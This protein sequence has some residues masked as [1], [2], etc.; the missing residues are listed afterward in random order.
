M[1]HLLLA[2]LQSVHH[3]LRRL[4]QTC[5]AQRAPLGEPDLGD[6]VLEEVRDHEGGVGVVQKELEQADLH[7]RQQVD[8]QIERRGVQVRARVD[9]ARDLRDHVVVQRREQREGALL[10]E[11]RQTDK[12]RSRS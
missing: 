6:E 2:A 1:R 11:V 3:V 5:E 7:A 4:L 10:P 12:S 8:Q 9:A